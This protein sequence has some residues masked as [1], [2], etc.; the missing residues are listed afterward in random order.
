MKRKV[1][2]I[3]LNIAL[4]NL[5]KHTEPFK[6]YSFV[7]QDNLICDWSVNRT[8]APLTYFGYEDYT[9]IHSETDAYR[10]A[11]GIMDY[12]I[13]FD[14]VN[15]RLSKKGILRGSCPCHS[16]YAYLKKLN[17]REIWFSTDIENFAELR[18]N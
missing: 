6:H 18:V 15:I 4:A 17:C 16:C 14:V 9:K 1:T 7:I 5:H 11:K 10:K 8:A 2:E 3:C 12:T 13:P